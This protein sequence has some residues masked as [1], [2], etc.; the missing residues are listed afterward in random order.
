MKTAQSNQDPI[1]LI[2]VITSLDLGGAEMMLFRL[3]SHIDRARFEN[4]VVSLIPAG[5]VG[6]NI[7]ALGIPVHSLRMQPGRPSMRAVFKLANLIRSERP[8]LLH[9][10]LYHADLVGGLAGLLTHTPVVW[11]IHNTSLDP[12]AVKSN[13]IKVAQFNARLS[14]WLPRKII[15]CSEAARRVH[16]GIG[17]SAN[18]FVVI[19]NGFD[20]SV[21]QVDPAARSSLRK[22]LVLPP[23]TVL[24]GLVARFDP[25]KD[26]QNFVQAARQFCFQHPQTHFLLCGEGIS[27]RN[28]QLAG[29][30]ETAGIRANCHLLGRRDDIPHVMAGL[31]M[32]TLSSIGE[33]FPNTLGEA[34]ACGVPCVAT[35]VGDSS[36]II[37]DT[38]MVVPPK[39]PQALA[40]AWVGLLSL[41]VEERLA[42]GERARQRIQQL[43]SIAQITRRYEDLYEQ[44][45]QVNR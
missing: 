5:L 33:A 32:L 13:T 10:W 20:L 15:T 30:I 6:D 36:Y 27:W 4:Q 25:L 44:V 28:E 40:D 7:R 31:D 29:W 2:H 24:I 26:H 38:G 17:Y 22:E 39:D 8:A 41:S 9:T 12:R 14:S 34:M 35:D 45:V 16:I 37:G 21:Y 23:D 11:G 3:L 1:K 19:P 42:L 43:F 18:K